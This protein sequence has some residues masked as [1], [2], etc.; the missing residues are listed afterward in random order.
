MKVA[1]YYS[2]EDIR[3]VDMPT[4]EI[5][6]GDILV[7][8]KACGVCG[9]DLMDWYLKPRTPLVLGHEPTGVIEK[10]GKKVDS[11]NVGDRVFVH[12][13]VACLSCHYCLHGDYTL[14]RQFHETN[15]KPGGFAEFFM[16][17]APNVQIDTLKLP[18]N[19]SFENATLIEPV[20]CCIRALKK[21]NFQAGDSVAVIGAG[22]TGL[23][24]A[25][26]SK[27]YGAS[28][29]VVSDLIEFR[30]RIASLYGADVTVNQV[31]MDL[32]ET[33]KAETDGRGVDLAIVTAPSLDAYNTALSVVRKGGKICVFA[34]SFPE[35]YLQ[36]SPERLFFTEQQFI[37]SYSTSHLETRSALRLLATHRI[38]AEHLITHRFTLDQTMQAFKTALKPKESLKVIVTN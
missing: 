35:K 6:D 29:T 7:N 17:P 27:I 22:A 8:M 12:H 5:D 30:L 34:P 32:A 18:N 24:H 37:P 33:V 13:H 25:A 16:A 10:K 21:C 38:D 14:C 4:P 31:N 2:Q 28:W 1:M 15:I 23:I 9:S 3:I 26:L 19:M 20:A 11:F 36:V